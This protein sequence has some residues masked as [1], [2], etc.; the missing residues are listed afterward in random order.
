MAT[1]LL[2]DKIIHVRATDKTIAYLDTLVKNIGK[3]KADIVAEALVLYFNQ[4]KAK[5]ILK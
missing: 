2:K 4:N 3:S 1:K 5:G